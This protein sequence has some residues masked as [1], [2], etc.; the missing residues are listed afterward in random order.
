VPRPELSFDKPANSLFE[1]S[2]NCMQMSMPP[3]M[4]PQ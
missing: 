4:P 2:A 1:H 3:G